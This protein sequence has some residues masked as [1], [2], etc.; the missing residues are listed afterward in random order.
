[1]GTILNQ[2]GVIPL[3][4]PYNVAPWNYAGTESVAS[5]PADV[6]DWILVELRETAGGPETATAGTMIDQRA[7]FLRN[8]G[9][10]VDLNGEEEMKFDI[11]TVTNDV[12]LVVWHRNH[13]G[14]MTP[15][16]L[17]LDIAP[18][19]HDFTTGE[20]Q[21]YGGADAH[22]DL[23]GGIY[24][25]MGGEADGNQQV[26]DQDKLGFWAPNAGTPAVYETFDFNMDNKVDNLDKNEIWVGNVNKQ[27]QVPD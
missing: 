27:T 15:A 26:T 9:K 18:I 14:V 12:Y 19:N 16:S 7:L 21:A 20:T 4:Q 17:A 2:K 24:G 22:K 1:M 8:D 6:V 13:L 10:I 5:I 11:A 23:G 3:S 25:L